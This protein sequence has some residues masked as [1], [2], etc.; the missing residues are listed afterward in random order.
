[1]RGF[2]QKYISFLDRKPLGLRN[3]GQNYSGGRVRVGALRLV[4]IT[5]LPQPH[6]NQSIIFVNTIQLLYILILFSFY[7]SDPVKEK[8]IVVMDDSSRVKEAW[9]EDL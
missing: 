5:P 8:T 3:L 7:Y 9:G 4:S 6:L 2:L 1:M